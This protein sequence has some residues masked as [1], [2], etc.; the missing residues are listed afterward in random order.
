MA[1]K[2][3]AELP[4]FNNNVPLNNSADAAGTGGVSIMCGMPWCRVHSEV[5]G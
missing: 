5:K 2:S 1:T 3:T 4:I